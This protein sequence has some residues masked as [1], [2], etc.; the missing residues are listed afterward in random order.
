MLCK[1]QRKKL[2]I[3]INSYCSKNGKSELKKY[4][5]NNKTGLN[6]KLKIVTDIFWKKKKIQKGCTGE[7]DTSICV[8]EVNK[9]Q[10]NVEES[11]VT[12]E[13]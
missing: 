13:E 12:L 9:N 6:S 3:C 1:I 8:K 5:E 11:I 2:R 7:T 10:K 4:C